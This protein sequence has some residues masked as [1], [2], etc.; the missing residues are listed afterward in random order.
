M[1]EFV[2]K[3]HCFYGHVKRALCSVS[4]VNTVVWDGR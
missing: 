1:V 3:Q 2:F 4:I